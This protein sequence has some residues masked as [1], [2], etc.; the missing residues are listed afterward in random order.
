MTGSVTLTSSQAS[1]TGT[2]SMT[3]SA[4]A[5][6]TWLYVSPSVSSW[7]ND[8]ISTTDD[9]QNVTLLNGRIIEIKI[10]GSGCVDY[11]RIN[12]RVTGSSSSSSSSSANT[13]AAGFAQSLSTQHNQQVRVQAAR[14]TLLTGLSVAKPGTLSQYADAELHIK[15]ET[16]LA[17]VNAKVLALPVAQRT[18]SDEIAKIIKLENFV[19][20]VSSS[21]VHSAS[22]SAQLVRNGFISADNRLKVS[23][24]NAL[25]SRPASTI[26]SVEELKA[27][28]VEETV[29]LQERVNRTAEI[30]SKIAARKR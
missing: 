15:S 30:K 24:A 16:A 1:G 29:R 20:E 6:A 28:I 2:T 25:R 27:A 21:D 11:Y 18:N 10:S 22:I 12:I 26:D 13:S 7:G 8:D 5:T 23:L 14:T 17:R 19:D 3:V 9:H 4:G